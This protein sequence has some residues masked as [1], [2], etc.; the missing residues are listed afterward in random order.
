MATELLFRLLRSDDLLAL[1]FEGVNLRLERGA[2]GG[3]IVPTGSPAL[4][5]V[6]FPPQQIAEETFSTGVSNQQARALLAG[7]SQLVFRVAAPLPF[8]LESL[9]DWN[10]P[11]LALVVPS[12]D[13]PAD[14]VATT[15]EFPYRL[16]L[17]PDPNTRWRHE[18]FPVLTNDRDGG[19]WA[20]LWR[21]EIDADPETRRV[22]AIGDQTHRRDR[23]V[24]LRR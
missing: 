11:E 21:T 14:Q 3:Q 23:P 19:R 8:T 9:L 12:A 22:W 2:G 1:D 20:E 4:L 5:I 7:T 6:R 24:R 18:R 15:I 10:R 13:S 16:L 17:A